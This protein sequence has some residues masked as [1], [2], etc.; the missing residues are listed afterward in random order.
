MKTKKF[1]PFL[2]ALG[3]LFLGQVSAQAEESADTNK[4]NDLVLIATVNIGD[5]KIISQD[6]NVFKLSFDLHNEQNV[7]PQVIYGVELVKQKETPLPTIEK[8][9]KKFQVVDQEAELQI[10][11]DQEIFRNDAVSLNP[12]ETINKEIT[13]SAPSSL[14]GKY[15]LILKARNSEGTILGVSSLG[16]ITLQ[17]AENS[18]LIDESSC[19]ISI[20]DDNSKE[21]RPQGGGI[22]VD[23]GNVL[24]M[25]CNIENKSSTSSQNIIPEITIYQRSVFGKVV[26]NQKFEALTF[27]PNEKSNKEFTIRVPGQPQTY[28]GIFILTDNKGNKISNEVDLIFGVNGEHGMIENV[29]LDKD[30]YSKGE[31]AKLQVWY[32]VNGGSVE[33]SSVSILIKDGK[34]TTCSQQLS[35]K[36]EAS[37]KSD[38]SIPLIKDCQN[39]TAEVV[40]K[41]KDGKILAQNSFSVETKNE[42]ANQEQIQEQ[43]QASKSS[44]GQK[45][46]IAGIILVLV[47]IGLLAFL[48]SKR[49]GLIVF[50]GL[51]FATSLFFAGQASA[52]T[53]TSSRF[54][55]QI[56]LNLNKTIPYYNENEDITL[57]STVSVNWPTNEK[58]SIRMGSSE[59]YAGPMEIPMQNGDPYTQI[60]NTRSA[61]NSMPYDNIAGGTYIPS[62][63]ET[64]QESCQIYYGTACAKTYE[65][66]IN[67]N[68]LA[69]TGCSSCTYPYPSKKGGFFYIFSGGVYLNS[70]MVNEEFYFQI[71]FQIKNPICG[72]HSGTCDTA[73]SCPTVGSA[74]TPPTPSCSFGT[75]SGLS[76]TGTAWCWTC[77]GQDSG[78]SPQCCVKKAIVP[79]DGVCGTATGG[80]FASSPTINLCSAGN[81]SG[82]WIDSINRWS[83]ICYGINGG[84]S[85]VCTAT[86]YVAP[87]TCVST[88]CPNSAGYCSGVSIT[89]NC[90][91]VCGTGTKCC[92][93]DS[94]PEKY[95]L[96]TNQTY[97]KTCG[98]SNTAICNGGKNCPTLTVGASSNVNISS[99]D[100]KINCTSG[101]P[102]PP[103]ACNHTYFGETTV[104]L[105]ATPVGPSLF[106]NWT[107]ACSASA[108]QEC[109]LYVDSP[110]TAGAIAEL[111]CNNTCETL[112]CGGLDCVDYNCNP[113]KTPPCDPGSGG[114]DWTWIEVKP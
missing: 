95:T 109:T 8:D 58:H 92:C 61:M 10:I 21:Y 73:G 91:K 81:P 57:T 49:K 112:S 29:L 79:V 89:D 60:I 23:P 36:Q 47:L 54:N 108:T 37:F 28:E 16:D 70:T 90:E 46:I 88:G 30:S 50:L 41:N 94:D 4:N 103:G 85:P 66:R 71:P 74:T 7:Q 14:D 17:S 26:D 39:P 101:S 51:L 13:Y 27:S 77:T 45:T 5:A 80:T 24:K 110:K 22:G 18:V 87:P 32:L 62:R 93:S 86:M 83:W 84:S 52:A 59:Y 35:E 15:A 98:A 6:G 55:Y 78:G 43:K 20:G 69:N 106:E 11:V 104:D 3:F 97:T 105:T 63:S 82:V 44:L 68:T 107:D 31:T 56:D 40:I 33:G 100:G 72:C 1:L 25:R 65:Q 76:D 113:G 2:L 102:I 34:G 19:R 111:H 9:G 38:Y 114:D 99:L 42:K 48:I 96:C 75:A 67:W 64:I 53:Y 12:G